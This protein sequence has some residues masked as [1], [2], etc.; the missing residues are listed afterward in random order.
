[1]KQGGGRQATL[2]G[3]RYCANGKTF[4][5]EFFFGTTGQKTPVETSPTRVL[6][7]CL[8]KAMVRDVLPSKRCD[9]MQQSCSAT[10]FLKLIGGATSQLGW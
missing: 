8:W 4:L 2:G 10:T 3:V 5:G 7:A 6:V 9:S 1:M